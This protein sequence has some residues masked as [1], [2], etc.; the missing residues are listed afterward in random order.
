MGN[1][2]RIWLTIAAILVIGTAATFYTR[3]LVSG[4]G[5]AGQESGS[6]AYAAEFHREETLQAEVQP[7]MFRSETEQTDGSVIRRED[8]GMESDGTDAAVPADAE[9]TPAAAAEGL[10][11]SPVYDPAAESSAETGVLWS[12]GYDSSENGTDP[13]TEQETL[14][15]ASISPLD[16]AETSGSSETSSGVSAYDQRLADI[17]DQVTRLR[18][19]DVQGTTLSMKMVADTELKLWDSELNVLYKDIMGR[20]EET[21]AQELIRDE[22]NWMSERDARAA[23]ASKKYAGGTLES[24]EYTATMA[25]ETRSRCYELAERYRNILSEN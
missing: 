22:R 2:Q 14:V 18:N 10:Q 3:Q 5:A 19:Q 12:S 24:L 23:E 17:D 1:N 9:D 15:P 6:T 11:G 7:R 21:E 4:T 20:L 13:V 25:A 8:V 16:G